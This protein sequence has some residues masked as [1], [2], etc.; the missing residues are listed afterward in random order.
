[1]YRI[2]PIFVLLFL[3][4]CRTDKGT[5]APYPHLA[6]GPNKEMKPPITL[7]EVRKELVQMQKNRPAPKRRP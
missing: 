1:M 6:D 5:E 2:L 4:H 3:T 7:E